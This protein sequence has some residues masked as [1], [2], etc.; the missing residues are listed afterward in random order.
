MNARTHFKHWDIVREDL[1]DAIDRLSEEHLDFVPV[2]GLWS[3][4][5]VLRH[6]A[7]AE[8]GWFRYVVERQYNEWPPDYTAE[9]YPTIASVKALLAETHARTDAYLE[10]LDEADL[11]TRIPTS[12][13]DTSIRW[14]IWHVIEHEIH[15]RGEVFL[16]LGMLG[17]AAPDI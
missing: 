5:T 10:A 9:D 7:N 1:I 16:M 12:G 15:H 6:I 11:D 2:A 17:I 14:V 3:L 8:E 4:G 13:G